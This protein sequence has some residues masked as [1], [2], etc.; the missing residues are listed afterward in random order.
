MPRLTEAEREAFLDEPGHLVRIGTVDDGGM[1][2]VVP[3]WFVERS[4]CL[5][6]TPR[7]CS[8]WYEHMQR[9]PRVCFTVDEEAAPYRKIMA[10][11]EIEVVWPLGYDDEWRDLYRDIAC[12][13]IDEFA[14]DAYLTAT[15]DEPRA[16]VAL[17][18]EDCSIIT[19]RM[20]V[21]GEDPRGVWASRYYQT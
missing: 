3:T 15:W 13:Y 18:L 8:A 9:D 14:A 2:W 6:V 17:A 20:P 7:A 5:Y 1:P 16:L 11:G 21:K 12:R 10:R 19:W 4:D